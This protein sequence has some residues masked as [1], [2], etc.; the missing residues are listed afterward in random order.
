[1]YGEFLKHESIVS[2]IIDFWTGKHFVSSSID[3]TIIIW[4]FE[5]KS[6][7]QIFKEE[8]K[9]ILNS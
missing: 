3:G 7:I 4:D 9:N 2:S 1:M 5:N 8:S 6:S